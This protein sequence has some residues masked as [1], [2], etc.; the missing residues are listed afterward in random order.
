MDE[1]LIRKIIEVNNVLAEWDPIGIGG[2][3]MRNPHI[4]YVQYINPILEDY[5]S[6]K[7]IYKYLISLKLSL[8]GGLD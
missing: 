8:A 1:N 6:K 4:E 5:H 2:H 3:D 7:S